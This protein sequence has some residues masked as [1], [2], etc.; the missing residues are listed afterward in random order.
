M[1]P[2]TWRNVDAPSLGDPSRTLALAQGS[3]NMGLD[4]LARP[5]Q[6]MEATGDANWK[7]AKEN[8]TNEMLNYL[9][10]FKS[11]EDAQAATNDGS[12]QNML[13]R[14]GAQVDQTKVRQA[15]ANVIPDL[16]QRY[17]QGIAYDNTKAAESEK[18]IVGAL[19]ALLPDAKNRK[20]LA[21]AAQQYQEAGMLRPAVV[22]DLLDKAR[23]Y[24]RN[25]DEWQLKLNADARAGAHLAMQQ[26]QLDEQTKDRKLREQQMRVAEIIQATQ[27]RAAGYQT[28]ISA[29][30]DNLKNSIF[31]GTSPNSEAGRKIITEAFRKT[32]ISDTE[33][34]ADFHDFWDGIRKTDNALLGKLQLITPKGDG[35]KV[36][37]LDQ[38]GN[39]VRDKSGNPSQ[40]VIPLT[41][42]MIQEAALRAKG[43]S[44][45][46]PSSGDILSSL[47]KM[48]RDPAL[49]AEYLAVQQK[50]QLKEALKG[51]VAK[52]QQEGADLLT[53]RLSVP[54]GD[55]SKK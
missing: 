28:E 39:V 23:N 33:L 52:V 18:P 19:M 46:D 26:R 30:A 34:T 36:D 50:Q 55:T 5:L 20:H 7:V 8:N 3:I 24:G 9:S 43:N 29:I 12:V 32:G 49:Q 21:E 6:Q 35:V 38:N 41:A 2:I 51:Q 44:W 15:Q 42:E 40:M 37:V 27:G 31:S 48:V 22:A 17:A 1:P 13:T 11:V 53:R 54:V 14:M 45:F 16:Q 47:G 10:G 25:D 4:Q